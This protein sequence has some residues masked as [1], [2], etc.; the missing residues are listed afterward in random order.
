MC[1]TLTC[2]LILVLLLPSS[3]WAVPI[4]SLPGQDIRAGD[5]VAG[6]AAPVVPSAKIPDSTIE[7]FIRNGSSS[8]FEVFFLDVRYGYDLVDFEFYKAWCLEE[9]KPILRNAMHKIRFYNCYDPGLPSKFASMK[10][11]QINYIINHKKVS[12]TVNQEA[13]WYFAGSRKKPLSPEAAQ[14]VEDANLN[15]KEYKPAEG[16]LLAV[17]CDTGEKK[18]PVFIEYPVP[19]AS[20]IAVSAPG[21]TS[22]ALRSFPFW[23]ALIPLLAIIP[24]I[25]TGPDSPP[26]PHPPPPPP[27][28]TTVPEPSTLLLLACGVAG[29]LASRKIRKRRR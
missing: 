29:A 24:F 3:G 16:E 4:E 23:L 26:G 2:I 27:P 13:I 6:V 1:K 12:R 28:P 25:G 22:P 18:Q 14:L 11:N 7:M 15:G 20:P 19:K 17:I 5:L 21:A 9:G 10:W 8:R